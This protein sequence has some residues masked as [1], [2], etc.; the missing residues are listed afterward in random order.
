MRIVERFV[1]VCVLVAALFLP[2]R[3]IAQTFD[4]IRLVPM[5]TIPVLLQSYFEA[6][7][8]LREETPGGDSHLSYSVR[9][10]TDWEKSTDAGLRNYV[11]NTSVAGEVA[12]YYGPPQ[13][14]KRS[15]FT[16]KALQL[17]Y[18][19][20]V[21]NWFINYV[22]T[23]GYTLQGF[24]Q[25]SEDKVEAL[26]VLVEGEQSYVVRASF[27]LNGRRMILAEYYVPY[28]L[29]HQEKSMQQSS[30]ASF[31]LLSFDKSVVE[32]LDTYNFLDLIEFQ[33]PISWSLRAS[34]IRSID[35][36]G[37]TLVNASKSGQM[38]GIIDIGVMSS[39][40]IGMKEDEISDKISEKMTKGIKSRTGFDIGNKI[41][42][43]TGYRFSPKIEKARIQAF[44]AKED[45]EKLVS[46]E[47]WVALLSEENYKYYI[48][49]VTPSRKDEF[50]TWARNIKTF[51][52]VAESIHSGISDNV[53]PDY[54][55]YNEYREQKKKED[56][57][58]GRVDKLDPFVRH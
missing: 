13:G 23:N 49:M 19:I 17:D 48:T 43:V 35:Q 56:L 15:M 24:L 8:T 40:I 47:I 28:D 32:I 2:F 39:D 4:I 42:D 41:E 37:V 34:A 10:P 36:M 38:N 11:L 53:D 16:V 21:R 20:S 14:D 51:Q 3:G 54:S 25:T 26:Y 7:T 22:L 58:K 30:I 31:K 52:R 33:Y 55:R 29:W 57:E 18:E 45:T 1:L 6:R 9:L 5:P 12:R 50:F 46:Y 27:Q 44:E